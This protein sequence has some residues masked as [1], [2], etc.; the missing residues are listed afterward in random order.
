MFGEEHADALVGAYREEL[1]ELDHLVRVFP[2]WPDVLRELGRRGYRLAV[3]TSK[4][5]LFASRH[6]RLTGLDL[7]IEVVVTAADV[8][9]H[10]PDPEPLLAV[11]SRLRARPQD[12]LVVGDNPYDL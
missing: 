6:L 12:C 3:V 8:R 1:A 11:A 2:E 4:G 9:N 10:K 5:R 7:L